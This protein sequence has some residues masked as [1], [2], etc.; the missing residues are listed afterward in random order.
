MTFKQL[1]AMTYG[2]MGLSLLV[3]AEVT[4]D[5]SLGPKNTIALKDNSYAIDSTLGRVVGRNLFHSFGR[6][7]L[8]T[9]T[10]ALFSHSG[11]NPIAN[12]IAR[13]TGGEPSSIDG[14]IQSLI[15]E[16]DLFLINP[17]GLF[18]GPHAQIDVPGSFHASTASMLSFEDGSHFAATPTANEILSTASPQ[19]FGF[20]DTLTD[21][22][23]E[24]IIQGSQLSV[25]D[26]GSLDLSAKNIQI[27]EGATL[28]SEAGGL[29]L[30]A[31][32]SVSLDLPINSQRPLPSQAPSADHAGDIALI[33]GVLY[34]NAPGG[35]Q[36][37]AWGNEIRIKN[38]YL[39][40]ESSG[41][42]PILP[43]NGIEINVNKL[44]VLEGG[45]IS[46]SVYSADQGGNIRIEAQSVNVTHQNTAILTTSDDQGNAGTLTINTDSFSITDGAQIGSSTY[47][48]GNAGLVSIKADQLTINDQNN[49]N[50]TGIFSTAEGLGGNAGSLLIEAGS[51]NILN[52]GNINASTYSDGDAGNVTVYANHLQID[53]QNGNSVTGIF[54]DTVNG[55]GQA[56]NIEINTGTLELVNG[57]RISSNTYSKGHAGSVTVFSQ[58][59]NIDR[60]LAFYN[61]GVFSD[62]YENSIGN[63][64]T[65][66]INTEFLNITNGGQISST[67]YAS[68]NAGTI[69]IT[70]NELNIDRQT[71]TNSTGIFSTAEGS[72]GNAGTLVIDS[73]SLKIVNGGSI[74]ASTFSNGDA[75]NVIVRAD[76]LIIDGQNNEEVTGIFSD[77]NTTDSIG[78]AGRIE[79]TANTLQ[80]VNGGR[81]SSNTYSEGNAGLV[82][83]FAK[84]MNIDRQLAFYKTGVFSDAYEDS[85]GNAGSLN[86]SSESLD[87]TN[88]GQ[89]SSTAYAAGN[90]GNVLVSANNLTIDNQ[91]SPNTTGIFSTSEG[92]GGNAGELIIEAR[93]LNILN[94]ALINSSTYTDGDAGNI[95]VTALEL[96]IDGQN[97]EAVTG[98]FSDTNTPESSGQAGSIEVTADTLQLVNGGRISSNTYSKGNAGAVSVFAKQMNID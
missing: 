38:T 64:G 63:A 85:T 80:L 18:F 39:G 84:Q 12:V 86:I 65:L 15:P 90:A 59:M 81:I 77:T 57:G 22:P 9:G 2:L 25:K 76:Q 11:V 97:S 27:T 37:A 29:R 48:S 66:S 53:G 24:M 98:I 58:Q 94:G 46:S 56:G 45:R 92:L 88:G 95:S 78:Q 14:T 8:E 47:A 69:L 96:N 54:S 91:F 5:G 40:L 19:S 21:S 32:G 42:S 28:G 89:I 71:S 79:V 20:L 31:A 49:I 68:G 33:D 50:A 55:A 87:I 23:G 34:S 52:G 10:T 30:V 17:S 43:A 6:F 70:A 26:A 7:N 16:A 44:E 82:S 60:Q 67:A 73:G 51:L 93:S 1:L 36:I 61:T 83:V 4:L 35:G 74:N 62:A 41:N 72:S 3:R 75:G 13:I